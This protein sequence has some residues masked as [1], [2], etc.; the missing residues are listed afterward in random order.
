MVREIHLV[1]QFYG[2]IPSKSDV[3]VKGIIECFF[4][5]T[6]NSFLIL[7]QKLSSNS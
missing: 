5:F 7:L 4:P 1:Q 6:Y 3:I 2:W